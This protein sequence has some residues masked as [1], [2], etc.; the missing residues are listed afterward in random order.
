M[1]MKVHAE[2]LEFE[3]RGEFDTMD[4]TARVDTA[5]RNSGIRE[6]IAIVNTGHT[7]GALILNEDE[8]GLQEDLKELMRRFAPA[9]GNYNHPNN[10]F[11]H[12]RSMLLSTSRVMPVHDG[13]LR[14][15]TW[16]SIY[17]VE[18]ERRPRNRIV[19]IAVI[20]S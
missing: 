20:G 13:N 19:E 16:Q 3:T 1:P 5:V 11:A 2:A 17:W 8:E 7:T 6:G 4:L 12:L 15:G 9:E 10:A 14:L 18:T